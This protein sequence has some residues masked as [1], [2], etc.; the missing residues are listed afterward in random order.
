MTAEYSEIYNNLFYDYLQSVRPTDS[1]FGFRETE[2]SLIRALRR[3]IERADTYNNLRS[4]AKYF[5]LVNFHQ[6]IIR[7]LIESGRNKR[8]I[9]EKQSFVYEDDIQ[10]DV[11]M[12]VS[13]AAR[14][15]DL[16]GI[17]G[18][19]IMRTVDSLWGQLRTAKFEIWG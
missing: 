9:S 2:Y 4:D 18:H 17:S 7:P 1:R 13:S 14:N 6:L 11:E 16:D 15:A 12:I 8:P 19:Q 10:A 3:S 5:L